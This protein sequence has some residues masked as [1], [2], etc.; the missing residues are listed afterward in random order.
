MISSKKKR[1][2]F[3]TFIK[4]S[5]MIYLFATINSLFIIIFFTTKCFPVHNF[6][7]CA[8]GC[9]GVRLFLVCVC[10]NSARHWGRKWMTKSLIIPKQFFAFYLLFAFHRLKNQLAISEIHSQFRC[11]SISW[12]SIVVIHA[13]NFSSS[14][15]YDLWYFKQLYK[16]LSWFYYSMWSEFNLLKV[17]KKLIFRLST[18]ELAPYERCI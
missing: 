4:V 11:F 1:K 2:N 8:W 9:S 5:N 13:C 14:K 12:N 7:T 3:Y 10:I 16:Q 18:I 15:I 6:I 17:N